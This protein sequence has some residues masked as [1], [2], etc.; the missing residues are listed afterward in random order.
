MDV[1]GCFAVK[2]TVRPPPP[3]LRE[4]PYVAIRRDQATLATHLLLPG[5]WLRALDAAGRAETLEA[6]ATA[7]AVAARLA[8]ALSAVELGAL[9]A[10]LGQLQAGLLAGD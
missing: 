10:I 8:P 9:A 4:P 6:G 3:P 7:Q 5:W 1:P 2:C